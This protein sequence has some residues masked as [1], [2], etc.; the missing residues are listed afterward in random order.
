MMSTAS[1]RE[2]SVQNQWRR[3]LPLSFIPLF[4]VSF[5]LS[6]TGDGSQ[7]PWWCVGSETKT[8]FFFS[9]LSLFRCVLLIWFLFCLLFCVELDY[10]LMVM[11]GL[12]EGV[13]IW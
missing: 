12:K 10:G 7:Q 11:G 9:F 1:E 5:L 2:A 3:I 13:I 8:S 4:Y 6:V